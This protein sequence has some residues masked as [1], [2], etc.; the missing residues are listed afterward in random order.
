M[1]YS[2]IKGKKKVKRLLSQDSSNCRSSTETHQVTALGQHLA[3]PCSVNWAGLKPWSSP[4]A[5]SHEQPLR[6]AGKALSSLRMGLLPIP[7]HPLCT[8]WGVGAVPATQVQSFAVSGG[9]SGMR[10]VM[11]GFPEQIRRARLPLPQSQ[12]RP[13]GRTGRG[14]GVPGAPGGS[15]GM[16]SPQWAGGL[17][18]WGPSSEVYTCTE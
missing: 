18:S 16:G 3:P 15:A 6:Q 1:K 14:S 7:A 9:D 11:A 10:E 2:Q 12:Q 8:V 13:A 5:L 17:F 4:S